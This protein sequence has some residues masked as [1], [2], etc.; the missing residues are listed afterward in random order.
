[1]QRD[2]ELSAL[3]QLK[4]IYILSYPAIIPTKLSPSSIPSNHRSP[5]CSIPSPD[6]HLFL[7]NPC[8]SF[9][10]PSFISSCW[11][12]R[13]VSATTPW[14]QSGHWRRAYSGLGTPPVHITPH[15]WP[16]GRRREAKKAIWPISNC[17]LL[18]QRTPSDCARFRSSSPSPLG[19]FLY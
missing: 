4:C 6:S 11:F 3:G 14:R 18:P 19:P 10:S 7:S 15:E 2:H 8:W 12:S 5:P 9:L 1:M 17:I 13:A 16:T